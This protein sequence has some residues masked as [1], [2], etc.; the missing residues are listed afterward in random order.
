MQKFDC[1]YTHLA[2]PDTSYLFLAYPVILFC[3]VRLLRIATKGEFLET[4][5]Y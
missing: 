4:Y 2:T 1:C 3:H 5:L